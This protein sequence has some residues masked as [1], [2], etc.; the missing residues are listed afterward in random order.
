MLVMATNARMNVM[1]AL[2]R[3]RLVLESNVID[4]APAPSI[5]ASSTPFDITH[6]NSTYPSRIKDHSHKRQGP[7]EE[8]T[9]VRTPA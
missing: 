4:G 3:D 1:Y 8:L 2:V 6:A 9:F 5:P 7:V